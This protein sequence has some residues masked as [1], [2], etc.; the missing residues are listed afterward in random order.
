MGNNLLPRQFGIQTVGVEFI[1]GI[2]TVAQIFGI[3]TVTL[4]R[5]KNRY[6]NSDF[7]VWDSNS[8][9][10]KVI[11]FEQFSQYLNPPKLMLFG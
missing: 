8:R 1:R 2:R 5:E 6:S 11:V 7:R 10:N 4:N 9:T 3:S